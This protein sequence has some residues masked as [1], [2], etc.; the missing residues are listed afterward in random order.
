[1]PVAGCPE[2]VG[3][4]HRV[5]S[6]AVSGPVDDDAV[7]VGVAEAAGVVGRAPAAGVAPRPTVTPPLPP[8]A[9]A[10]GR[11]DVDE[12]AGRDSVPCEGAAVLPA[13]RDKAALPLEDAVAEEMVRWGGAASPARPVAATETGAPSSS[14]VELVEPPAL[15]AA[16]RNDSATDASRR[17]GELAERWRGALPATKLDSEVVGTRNEVGE[18][19]DIASLPTPALPGDGRKVRGAASE[20]GMSPPNSVGDG[21]GACKAAASSNDRPPTSPYALAGGATPAMAT[22]PP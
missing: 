14:V 15:A 8:L 5:V 12:Y 13:A 2:L 9:E 17:N 21:D 22:V 16:A 11:C 19:S 6:H 10:R 1:M 18:G 4:G 20:R 7:G 3:V